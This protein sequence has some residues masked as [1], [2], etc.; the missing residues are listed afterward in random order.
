MDPNITDCAN[1]NQAKCP[2]MATYQLECDTLT[3]RTI[4]NT[5]YCVKQ[6]DRGIGRYF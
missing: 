2:E 6:S 5:L 1:I 4:H 3:F